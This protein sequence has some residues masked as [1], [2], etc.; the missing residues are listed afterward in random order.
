MAARSSDLADQ[1]DDVEQQRE[2]ANL[3]MWVFIAAEIMF[4]GGMLVCYVAYMLSYPRD[5]ARASNHTRILLGAAN[6]GI[7][8]TSSFTMALAVLAAKKGKRGSLVGFLLATITLGLAFLSLKAIEYGQ[9]YR[10]HLVPG[11]G[12]SL[13]GADLERGQ[14]F[15]GFYFVM[16]A[17]H[18][19]HMMI[20]IGVLLVLVTLAWRKH[21]SPDHHNPVE[22]TGLYWHFVDIVWIFLF[23]LLYLTGRHLS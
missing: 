19:L 17:V 4:F 1:F 15:F 12:F 2:A 18:A 14:L 7:L 22:V 9:D 5:F 16:T 3:G 23:P 20:G 10:E 11:P 8:L 13:N 21:F 6:T